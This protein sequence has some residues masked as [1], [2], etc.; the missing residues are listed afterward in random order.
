M[1]IAARSAA[2]IGLGFL[3]IDLL[4]EVAVKA[5]ALMTGQGGGG[6]PQRL[7][8]AAKAAARSRMLLIVLWFHAVRPFFVMTLASVRI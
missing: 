5:V 3:G 8:Q 1:V 7:D 4:R 6:A 2:S